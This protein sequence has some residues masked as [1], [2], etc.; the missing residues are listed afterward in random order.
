MK[1]LRN[2]M[3][4]KTN[5]EHEILITDSRDI[6]FQD[7]EILAYL[8]DVSYQGTIDHEGESIDQCVQEMQDTISGKYG[9]FVTQ[10][11]KLI[12]RDGKAVAACLIT[13]WKDKP[14]IAFSMTDPSYQR[15]GL[16]RNL[17]LEA[18]KALSQ[19]G[20]KVLYLVVTESNTP[21]QSLY[22]KI[23]FKDLGEALPGQP[24]P[25]IY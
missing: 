13:M 16:S 25:L 14:L 8:M 3:A 1:R 5:T 10:A 22:R 12:V 17:I 18:M 6:R 15:Q 7:V 4:V 20:E 9:S 21:A 23:G 2:W 11:S 24:P 19:S